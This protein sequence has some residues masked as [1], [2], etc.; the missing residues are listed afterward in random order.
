MTNNF[1]HCPPYSADLQAG[2]PGVRFPAGAA[3]FSLHHRVQIGS[4]AQPASYPMGTTR[5]FPGGKA[6]GPWR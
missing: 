5:S 4:G 6:T 3:N 1:W 2:W